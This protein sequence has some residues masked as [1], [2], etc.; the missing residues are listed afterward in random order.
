MKMRILSAIHSKVTKDDVKGN[1]DSDFSF[2]QAL[3]H[4]DRYVVAFSCQRNIVDCYKAI[5][6]GL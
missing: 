5:Y 3:S 6:F 4:V 1:E 2:L